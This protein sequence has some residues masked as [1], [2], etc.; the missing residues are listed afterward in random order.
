MTAVAIIVVIAAYFW[1]AIPVTHL[2]VKAMRGVDLR[3]YGSGSVGPSNAA[4]LVGRRIAIA[5]GVVEVLKGA[6]PIWVA[7]AVDLEI[8]QQMAAGVAC[9]VGHN[10]SVWIRFKGG[11]GMS[12]LLGVML[13]MARLELLL[14]TIIALFGIAFW[15]SVPLFLGLSAAL[16]PMW[17]WLL[18]RSEAYILGLGLMVLVIALKRLLGN[19]LPEKWSERIIF[20]RL[21]FD[22]DVR[23]RDEW[24]RRGIKTKPAGDDSSPPP[25]SPRRPRPPRPPAPPSPKPPAPP[26][27]RP[28]APPPRPP[29]PPP[30]P[31]PPAPP[32]PPRPPAPPPPFPPAPPPPPPPPPRPPSPPPPPPPYPAPYPPEDPRRSPR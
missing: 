10:W 19:E 16:L 21:L 29:A 15:S 6:A 11:R 22:R 4:H 7:Q 31:R 26:P 20:Y 18:E 14:V 23:D 28:P 32:P 8:G 30:P 25:P 17:S 5:I 3:D 2:V 27:P 1:G 24:V 9:I 13:A 12:I